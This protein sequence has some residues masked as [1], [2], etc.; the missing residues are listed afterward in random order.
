MTN[1]L[2]VRNYSVGCVQN[3]LDRSADSFGRPFDRPFGEL[4]TSLRD[5]SGVC[6]ARSFGGEQSWTNE[7]NGTRTA[8]L[9]EK[10]VNR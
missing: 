9:R 10:P 7:V 4:R 8:T 5:R 6:S 2:L 1:T 3:E